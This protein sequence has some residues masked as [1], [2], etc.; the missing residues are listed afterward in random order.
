M[1]TFGD[2]V[3]EILDRS[4]TSRPVDPATYLE[5]YPEHADKL[6]KFFS[7]MELINSALDEQC[8]QGLPFALPKRS[9]VAGVGEPHVP[10]LMR[11]VP[12]EDD[13]L[14]GYRIELEIHSGA[15]GD[16]YRAVQL[17]TGR[18]VA[19]K[20]LRAMSTEA[21]A[22]FDREVKLLAGLRHPN[23]VTVHDA[24][25]VRSRPYCAM[26]FIDGLPLDRYL[27]E[28]ALTTE[29]KLRLF[30]GICAGVMHAHHYGVIH[31]DLKP[32]N[33]LV[34]DRGKPR[35]ALTCIDR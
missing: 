2:L 26:E 19:V 5:E 20:I 3:V 30:L 27:A 33:V 28:Q 1:R 6:K 29:K 12:S 9:V 13:L 23:I 7:S 32:S 34:D 18:S 8:L 25:V 14:P 24:G 17:S 11:T 21:L 16:V 10:R 22:W 15:Q 31:R 35:N 4:G